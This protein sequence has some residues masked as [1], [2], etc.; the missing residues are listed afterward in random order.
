MPV[1]ARQKLLHLSLHDGES[2]DEDDSEDGSDST[3][4]KEIRIPYG[5]R[6]DR[7]YSLFH[8]G[9]TYKFLILDSCFHLLFGNI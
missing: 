6:K 7:V 8:N 1:W 2:Y 3:M 4:T 9:D 5:F